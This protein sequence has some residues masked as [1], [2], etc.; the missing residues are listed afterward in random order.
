VVIVGAALVVLWRSSGG[1]RIARQT[2]RLARPLD[3]AMKIFQARI[4]APGNHRSRRGGLSDEKNKYADAKRN[5]WNRQSVCPHAP[6]QIARYYVALSEEHLKKFD[7]AEKNLKLVG[8]Q[9]RRFA[10]GG[11]PAFQLAWVYSPK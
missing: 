2:T 3:D 8:V 6:G 9:R 7:D 10:H 5:S 11:L 4:H 1:A